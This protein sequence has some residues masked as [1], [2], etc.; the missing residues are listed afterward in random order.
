MLKSDF[1][2]TEMDRSEESMEEETTGTPSEPED[3]ET[4]TEEDKFIDTV[5]ERASKYT[6]AW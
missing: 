4:G 5:R 6:R 1:S 2:L 3:G